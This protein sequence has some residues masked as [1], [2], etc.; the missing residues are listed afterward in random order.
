MGFHTALWYAYKS[1]LSQATWSPCCPRVLII[2]QAK[3]RDQKPALVH[4]AWTLPIYIV[5][6][7][8]TIILA[9]Q[10]L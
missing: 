2:T 5:K 3:G 7:L 9:R 4:K 8:S 6:P 1:M 10:T